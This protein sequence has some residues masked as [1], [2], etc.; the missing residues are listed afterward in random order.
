LVVEKFQAGFQV[1]GTPTRNGLWDNPK[2]LR[3]ALKRRALMQLQKCAGA[4]ENSCRKLPSAQKR[5]QIP[6]IGFG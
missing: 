3:H 4:P 1:G 5:C 2:S 6:F